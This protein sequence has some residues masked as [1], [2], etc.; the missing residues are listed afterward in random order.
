LR[1]VDPGSQLLLAFALLSLLGLTQLQKLVLR[2]FSLA[3]QAFGAIWLWLL[4]LL[5]ISFL[6]SGASFLLAWP[7]LALLLVWC[8]IASIGR[9][10]H[11]A[12]ALWL[13][14]AASLVGIILF[15]PMIRQ[16]NVALGFEMLA[17]PLVFTLWLGA[18]LTPLT[19]LL[20]RGKRV[21]ALMLVLLVGGTIGTLATINHA[22]QYPEEKQLFYAHKLGQ[23]LDR[24]WWLSPNDEIRSTLQ[25]AGPST[26]LNLFSGQTQRHDMTELFG[27]QSA[28]AKWQFWREATTPWALP[29]TT[30]AV[31]SDSLKTGHRYD[32]RELVLHVQGA[33]QAA[34]LRFE[35]V[36]ASVKRSWLNDLPLTTQLEKN[37]RARIESVPVQGVTLRLLLSNNK[38]FTLRLTDLYYSIPPGVGTVTLPE[39]KGLNFSGMVIQSHDIP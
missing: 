16:F 23:T 26:A 20:L 17:A 35:V 27:A 6:M 5:A 3:E 18:L 39:V 2:W 33:P 24:A 13:T 9:L 1:E 29:H 4:G 10:Q 19:G 7:L 8:A 30:F 15:A 14:L 21:L 31:R 37:W 32:G 12:I 28:L 11:P 38:P 34:A 36:G 22:K 25:S